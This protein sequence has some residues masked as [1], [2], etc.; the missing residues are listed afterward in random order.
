MEIPHLITIIGCV[1]GLSWTSVLQAAEPPSPTPTPKPGTLA[2]I[3]S[4]RSLNRAPELA[5]AGILMI[6]DDNLNQLSR[7]AALTVLTSTIADPAAVEADH[8]ADPK[9]RENWRKKV[10]A[11]GS[12][13]AKLEARRT[14]IEEE[15][16]RLERGKLDGRTLDRIAM[17]EGKLQTIDAEIRSEKSQLSKI[18]REA[19][20]D[21]AQP[22]WFR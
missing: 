6:T 21:G 10:L 17:A 2:A 3:A 4:S 19:R 11:Q 9:T 5:G 7:G 15:L 13:I 14:D 20:K 8:P 16:N 1:F 18:I 22:G 12:V